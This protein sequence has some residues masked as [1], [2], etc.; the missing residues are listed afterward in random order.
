MKIQ[1]QQLLG[2]ACTTLLLLGLTSAADAA[3]II[4]TGLNAGDS[5]H[6]V[7]TS[8]TKRDGTSSNIADYDTH[9]QAAADAAGIGASEGISWLAIA[10]TS[11][12]NATDHLASLFTSTSNTPI[13]NQHGDL[14]S[15][16]FDSLWDL[17]LNSAVNYTE[18][19]DL[20]GTLVWT[21][22]NGVGEALSSRFM[23]DSGT[24]GVYV[25]YAGSAGMEWLNQT[26]DLA[27]FNHSLYALS[28]EL[29]VPPSAVPVPAAVWL[30]GSGLIGLIGIAR[31]KKA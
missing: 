25:G 11:T 23:G 20:T 31:R 16:S 4:P 26:S 12:V 21:G 24:N 5:Y 9:V 17:T 13:Y 15:T 1:K 10:S 29:V 28:S 8:S 3:I 30:F 7:F 27:Q 14:V 18:Y 6:V 19:G 22:S 2:I